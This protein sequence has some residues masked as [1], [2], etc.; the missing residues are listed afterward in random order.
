LIGNLPALAS[1]LAMVT[2]VVVGVGAAVKKG[3]DFAEAGANL[4]RLETA[5]QGLAAGLGGSYDVLMD[6]LRQASMNTVSNSELMLSANRAMMLGLGGDAEKMGQLMEVAGFRG[7]AMGL[8]T[9][10]AFSDIV[11]GIGRASPLILD[12]LGIIL[13]AEE[14]YKRYAETIGKSADDLTKAEQTQALLNATIADGQRQ[15]AAAG[16]LAADNATAFEQWEAASANL[17]DAWKTKLIPTGVAVANVL[18]LAITWNSKLKDAVQKHHDVVIKSTGSWEDY[19]TEMV[20]A[21]G[22]SKGWS[23]EVIQ[24]ATEQIILTGVTKDL[25]REYGLVDQAAFEAEKTQKAYNQQLEAGKEAQDNYNK[26][27]EKTARLLPS[28]GKEGGLSELRMEPGQ[29]EAL[30]KFNAGLYTTGRRLEEAK[31]KAEEAKKPIMGVLDLMSGEMSS[32]IAGFIEDLK[33]FQAGGWRIEAAFEALKGGLESGR[34]TPAEAEVWAGELYKATEDMQV[35]LGKLNVD[36]AADNISQTLG[37]TKDEARQYILGT[38]GIQGA[39]DQITGT[40]WQI[41]IKVQYSG[42]LPPGVPL[43]GSLQPAKPTRSTTPTKPGYVKAL[44]TGGSFLVPPGFSE[45]AGNP[46]WIALS[47]GERV[48]VDAHG[49]RS[50]GNGGSVV[51]YGDIVVMGGGEPGDV[52]AEV[53]MALQE[54]VSRSARAGAMYSGA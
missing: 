43:P 46:Y 15:I 8:S 54:Q 41:N 26:E 25:G 36:E 2:G 6:K 3:L 27:L 31:K 30:Q 32:P 37:I 24:A 14:T 22:V 18:T 42:Q 10:Q 11:T 44:A 29:A 7:R 35:E 20:R 34:I 33:W 21:I 12:N 52:Y 47:S 53:A 5:G 4:Q 39:L 50:Q 1:K 45:M 19:I 48:D 17:A 23:N 28:V 51:L 9:S 16:G 38:D 49:S 40:E 13:N